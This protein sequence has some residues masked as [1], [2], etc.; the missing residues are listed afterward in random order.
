MQDQTIREGSGQDHWAEH[1]VV[2]DLLV[3]SHPALWTM[4]ELGRAISSSDEACKADEASLAGVE[5]ALQ[6]LYGAGLVHRVGQFAF[7]SRAATE[8]ARLRDA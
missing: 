1:R 2:L 4:A 3:S 6:D 7:A 5:D 8:S